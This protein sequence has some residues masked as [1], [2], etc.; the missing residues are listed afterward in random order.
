HAW[1]V[2]LLYHDRLREALPPL[3]EALS[4]AEKTERPHLYLRCL[5]LYAHALADTGD[6]IAASAVV[7]GA[8][9]SS[10]LM[11]SDHGMLPAEGHT[12]SHIAYQRDE[13]DEARS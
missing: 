1:G 13:L 7:D 10:E 6:L 3:S 11:S 4:L 12:A 5:D 9:A 2:T 8:R